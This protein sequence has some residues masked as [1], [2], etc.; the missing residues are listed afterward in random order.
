[1]VPERRN[2]KLCDCGS[3][4]PVL[5][6]GRCRSCASRLANKTRKINARDAQLRLT[7][8]GFDETAEMD[9]D[10]IQL[11]REVKLFTGVPR[12]LISSLVEVSSASED[13]LLEL[14]GILAGRAATDNP[15][16]DRELLQWVCA[17]AAQLRAVHLLGLDAEPFVADVPERDR[18]ADVVS[19]ELHRLARELDLLYRR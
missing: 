13:L 3:G 5:S 8:S 14:R 6:T 4:K 9:K 15:E 1:M 18:T 10:V 7:P 16:V 11:R 17:A 12:Q 19:S 2:V